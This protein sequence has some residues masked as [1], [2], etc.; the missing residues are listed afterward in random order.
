M[1]L[2]PVVFIA[3]VLAAA[4]GG[5]GKTDASRGS[6]DSPG[7]EVGP[8]GP[9]L[10]AVAPVVRSATLTTSGAIAGEYR[11]SSG[12]EVT[13]LRGTCNPE[14]WANFGIDLPPGDYYRL[15]VTLTSKDEIPTGATGEFKLDRL[16]V[17]FTTEDMESLY[18]RGPGVLKLTT[19]DAA[20]GRR[21]MVGTMSGQGLEGRED[22]EGQNLDATLAFDMDFSCG[23]EE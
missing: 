22:A 2:R 15:Q 8:F 11:G 3:L 13:G 7:V 18:F 1:S 12:D 21:R 20:P 10:G 16:D 14:M 19:H 17:E 23:V 4:C 9:P 5:P 6:A